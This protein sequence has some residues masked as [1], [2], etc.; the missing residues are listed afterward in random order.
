MPYEE[1]D[2]LTQKLLTIAQGSC[3]ANAT[4]V[5]KEGLWPQE[6]IQS[7]KDSGLAGLL[8]PKSAGGHGL[9]YLAMVKA[10]EII[11]KECSST[12]MCYGMH[13]VGSAVI[14]AKATKS[15]H[16]KFLKPIA[17]GKHWTTLALSEPGTGSHFYI[18]Q[19]KLTGG[20]GESLTVSGK[21]SF[22]TNGL[23]ADSYV[24][25]TT[26]ETSPQDIGK[27]SC[28][29][30][31]KES[32]GMKWGAPWKG[33]G[34][35]G[36]SSC[37]LELDNISIPE[38]NLLGEVGDQLWYVFEVIAPK[39]LIAMSGTYLGIAEAALAEATNHLKK[40]LYNHS[41][42]SL[43]DLPVLQHR[44]GCLWSQVERT[45]QLVYSAAS[46]GDSGDPQAS[47]SIMSCKAEVADCVVN[48]VNECMTLMGGE[49]YGY[50]G[51]MSRH[52]RDARAAHVMSP[53][54]DI[55]RTWTG[56]AL[57]GLPLLGD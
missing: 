45:R 21:K 35:R 28:L 26:T 12:A 15:H 42:S 1:F 56:R 55:L 46:L 38:E 2:Q 43:A 7:L 11:A 24:V 9:G 34:M 31:P 22:V 41:G 17:Q 47:L 16:E 37:A 25:S 40:R 53:T 33:L 51:S 32:K 44:L 57:L 10:L 30:L 27:F 14:A 19:A 6:S 3:R 8:V 23:H 20:K 49:A 4:L 36:N 18:P 50:S 54:T 13:L 52:L 5:D 29:V 39:F 48:V